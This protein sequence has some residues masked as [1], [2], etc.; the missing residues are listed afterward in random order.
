MGES[1]NRLHPLPIAAGG[2]QCSKRH[3]QTTSDE[4]YDSIV[5]ADE[6]GQKSCCRRH[7]EPI[8][9]PALSLPLLWGAFPDSIRD[10]AHQV[11]SLYQ[12]LQEFMLDC[13]KLQGCVER[14]E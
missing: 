11:V 6:T 9:E 5:I 8:I 1:R 3:P 14:T 13:K 2:T 10:L 7:L 4:L 12:H